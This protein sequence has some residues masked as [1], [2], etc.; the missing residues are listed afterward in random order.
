MILNNIISYL[1][2]AQNYPIRSHPLF[3]VIYDRPRAF[4]S[5]LSLELQLACFYNLLYMLF[6][7]FFSSSI[8]EYWACNYYS[9]FLCIFICSLNILVLPS[10]LLILTYLKYKSE[11]IGNHSLNVLSFFNSPI[12]NFNQ[13]IS[14]ILILFYFLLFYDLFDFVGVNSSNYSCNNHLEI[15]LYTILFLFGFLVKFAISYYRFREMYY[16]KYLGYG[17]I[18]PN[19][20]KTMKIE[21]ILNDK[22]LEEI[23]DKMGKCVICWEEFN[24]NEE[25]RTLSCN[26]KHFFHRTCV[27]QW[28]EKYSKCPICTHIFE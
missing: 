12:M 7:I 4:M 21:T 19:I 17:K 22:T 10:K 3:D 15:K 18:D 14:K 27:D 6:F 13:I 20:L 28:L 9:T 25:I 8:E 24:L 11:L 23:K 1:F 26:I 5:Y 16:R 2:I